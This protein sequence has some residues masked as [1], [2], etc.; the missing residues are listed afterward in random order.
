MKRLL[1]VV[2]VAC[3]GG[4]S[5]HPPASWDDTV[6]QFAEAWCNWNYTCNAR[7]DTGCVMETT[8]VMTMQTKPELTPAQQD[9][10]VNC[11]AAWT[12]VLAADTDPCTSML[13]FDQMQTTMQA[14]AS[15]NC[16]ENHDLPGSGPQ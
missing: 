16:I 14:C 6:A 4:V 9:I 11:M 15:A 5:E 7:Q 8:G 12:D 10:C 1:L 2:L 3:G 13:T